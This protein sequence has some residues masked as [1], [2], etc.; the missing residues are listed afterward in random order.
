MPH[1]DVDEHHH[2]RVVEDGGRGRT[3]EHVP[4]ELEDGVRGLW[5]VSEDAHRVI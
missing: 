4:Q 2:V 1:S 3:G 5:L